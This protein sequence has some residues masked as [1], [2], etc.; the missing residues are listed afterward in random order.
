M[1]PRGQMGM[2]DV[3]SGCKQVIEVKDDEVEETT[4]CLK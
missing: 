3:V 2:L 4:E 1:Q